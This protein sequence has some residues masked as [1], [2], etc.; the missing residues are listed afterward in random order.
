[1]ASN[2]PCRQLHPASHIYLNGN[3]H[4]R[5][6]VV[7]HWEDAVGNGVEN[8]AEKCTDTPSEVWPELKWSQKG[9]SRWK[10]LPHVFATP[11]PF[12]HI[13]IS[14]HCIR[15]PS[16]RKAIVAFSNSI[17]L[18]P[19]IGDMCFC[20]SSE[21]LVL[22]LSSRAKSTNSNLI[23]YYILALSV[24]S[25]WMY[26]LIHSIHILCC[27]IFNV[28]Y[29]YIFMKGVFGILVSMAPLQSKIP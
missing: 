27:V 22:V 2:M 16:V 10:S 17:G 11:Q 29:I 5:P 19:K 9:G 1:M 13:S 8:T 6:A 18:P 7:S 14:T 21:P 20:Y 26:S 28:E 24:F 25:W 15:P 3:V 4:S 23:A 12:F